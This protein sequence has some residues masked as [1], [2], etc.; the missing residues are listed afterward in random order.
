MDKCYKSRFIFNF[1]KLNSPIVLFNFPLSL[2]LPQFL[3]IT[4]YLIRSIQIIKTLVILE[5]EMNCAKVNLLR[6]LPEEMVK[7]SYK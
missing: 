5:L 7:N 3:L 2:P 1:L 6:I 4:Q